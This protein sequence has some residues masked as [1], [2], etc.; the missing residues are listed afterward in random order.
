LVFAILLACTASAVAL[1]QPISGRG[2]KFKHSRFGALLIFKSRDPSFLFPPIGSADDPA[3]GSPGGMTVDVFTQSKGPAAGS[4]PPGSGNPG[5]TAV[6]GAVDSYVYRAA[7]P[8]FQKVRLREGRA[9]QLRN[10]GFGLDHDRPLGTVAIRITT[11][12]RRS[13]AVFGPGTLVRDD[14]GSFTARDAPAPAI[15]DCSDGSLLAAMGSPCAAPDAWPTCGGPCPE[16]GVCASQ[17]GS[18]TC[19]F[20]SQLCGGTAPVCNGE[21]PA[22]EE[23]FPF[24]FGLPGAGDACACSPAGVIP[25]GATDA[26]SCGGA[27]DA[28]E[29]CVP[30]QDDNGSFCRCAN[31]GQ[32]CG[33]ELGACP[34]DLVCRFVGFP[35]N[36]ACAPTFCGGTFPTCGGTC[37]DGRACVPLEVVGA[38]ACVCATP[39]SSCDDPACGS[40]LACPSGEICTV[41]VS[42]G[43]FTCSCEAP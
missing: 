8:E 34:L 23:C 15:A 32:P 10:R 29:A 22:G 4:V 25:C 21:C 14:P 30:V 33:P 39:G 35:E 16:S 26:P 2:L 6:D 13:C 11:G 37:G 18:C 12:T 40:G 36:W 7:A 27:C 24:E 31:E 28:G 41:G 3:T 19:I 43:E 42:G 5:W 38:G 9:L 17:S 1:D 20:P